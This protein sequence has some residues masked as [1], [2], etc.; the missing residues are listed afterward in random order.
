MHGE[1]PSTEPDPVETISTAE[2]AWM[3]GVTRDAI[4]KRVEGGSLASIRTGHGK[5]RYRIPR[6]VAQHERASL[7]ARLHAVEPSDAEPALRGR[8][9]ELQAEADSLRAEVARVTSALRSLAVSEK[10]ALDTLSTLIALSKDSG[11]TG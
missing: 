9:A 8:I 6:Q 7:L 10:A 1:A 2:M 3:L 5:G 4:V 11:P